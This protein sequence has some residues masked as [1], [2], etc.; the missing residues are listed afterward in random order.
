MGCI[1]FCIVVDILYLN[2]IVK[3]QEDDLKKY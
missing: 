1:E 2:E 3:I